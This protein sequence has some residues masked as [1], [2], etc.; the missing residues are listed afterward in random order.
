MKR[1][2]SLSDELVMKYSNGYCNGCSNPSSSGNPRHLGYPTWWLDAA[3]VPQKQG[4]DEEGIGSSVVGGVEQ[5]IKDFVDKVEQ[6]I[7]S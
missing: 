1:F 6:I 5:I 2:W 7:T 3:Y 4:G